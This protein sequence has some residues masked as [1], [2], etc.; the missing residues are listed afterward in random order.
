MKATD[1]ARKRAAS[2]PAAK[3]SR[4]YRA[5]AGAEQTATRTKGT[6]GKVPPPSV[7]DSGKARA[8]VSPKK[9]AAASRPGKKTQAKSMASDAPEFM[10]PPESF[11]SGEGLGMN[12]RQMR[13]Y[14][15]WVFDN[16][17][18]EG[19]LINGELLLPRNGKPVVAITSHGPGI[20][21]VPLVALVGRLYEEKGLGETIGG[22]FPHPAVFWVPGLRAYYEKHLG[23]PTMIQSVDDMVDL[24]KKGRIGITGTAPEGA[25]CLISFDEYVGPFRSMGMISAAIRA[26]ADITMVAHQGAEPWSIRLNLPFG[27]T[28]PL[29]RG[30]RGVN[31][32]LPPYKRLSHYVALC[33]KFTPMA[34]PADLALMSKR[35]QRFVFGLEAER[36]RAEMNLMTD[37]VKDIMAQKK[38]VRR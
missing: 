38:R 22:M 1:P 13:P 32:A 35:E 23:T 7:Y 5:S 26:E 28:V 11:S 10:A 9:A 36:M 19:E 21:W 29:T 33:R 27:W 2:A 4:S 34:T 15:D 18:D 24:L 17:I 37:E 31:I 30:V 3:A 16:L 8:A 20:A 14:M 12:M 25:N 6:N